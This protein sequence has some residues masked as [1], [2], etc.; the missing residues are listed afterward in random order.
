MG[1]GT[2]VGNL[3]SFWPRLCFGSGCVC[4]LGN[5]DVH[6]FVCSGTWLSA[7]GPRAGGCQIDWILLI[8]SPSPK[9]DRKQILGAPPCSFPPYL[10]PSQTREK[11]WFYFLKNKSLSWWHLRAPVTLLVVTAGCCADQGC[12]VDSEPVLP[13]TILLDEIAF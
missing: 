11:D 12:R 13:P 2:H 3:T 4:L 8:F 7:G 1:R 10:L 9:V 6:P 5:G